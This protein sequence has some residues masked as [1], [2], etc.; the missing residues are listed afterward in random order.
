MS[1]ATA[2]G[3]AVAASAVTGPARGT[4]PGGNES[5]GA[6]RIAIFVIGGVLNLLGLA[7]WLLSVLLCAPLMLAGFWVW[8]HEFDWAKRLL[9]RVRAWAGSLWRRAR[10]HPVR[11]GVAAAL[12]L[13]ATATAYWWWL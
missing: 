12:S 13:A 7:A 11:W 9:H 2:R 3:P 8:S 5:T 10:A 6:R 1:P 4:L